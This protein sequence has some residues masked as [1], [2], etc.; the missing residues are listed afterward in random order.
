[1]S[2]GSPDGIDEKPTL[3]PSGPQTRLSNVRVRYA[4]AEARSTTTVGTAVRDVRC[5]PEQ[6]QRSVCDDSR[7]A[8]PMG[9]GRRTVGIPFPRCRG[10]ES[11]SFEMS[12]CRASRAHVH[13]LQLNWTASPT[14]ATVHHCVCSQL[15][16]SGHL[17]S[18][19]RSCTNDGERADSS[20]L[21]GDVRALDEFHP[22]AAVASGA[23]YRGRRGRIA[24]RVPPRTGT[25]AV[26]GG[27]PH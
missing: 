25:P 7:H 10:A 23:E 24:D 26:L 14:E 6:G 19:G 5:G 9:S 18:R 8:H 12:G 22:S 17:S 2:S 16:G 27:L 4:T 21:S 15:V 13:F 3:A 20:H 11:A 1:M